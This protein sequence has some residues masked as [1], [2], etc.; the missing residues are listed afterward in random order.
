MIVHFL[1][2][3]GGHASVDASGTIIL[4]GTLDDHFDVVVRTGSVAG[5]FDDITL[6]ELAL[7]AISCRDITV[8][9]RHKNAVLGIECWRQLVSLGR[10]VLRRF[11]RGLM[12]RS[13]LFYL[14]S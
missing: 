11:C 2:I 5:A 9:G 7:G 3:A 14:L 8:A 12:R 10:S 1:Q 4:L 13:L 6:T